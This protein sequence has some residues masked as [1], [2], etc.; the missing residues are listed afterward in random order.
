[1]LPKKNSDGTY[2][3]NTLKKV[4]DP[5]KGN[6]S[7]LKGKKAESKLSDAEEYKGVL[8]KPLVLTNKFNDQIN[9]T[10]TSEEI[11][12]IVGDVGSEINEDL[13][14]W[15]LFGNANQG[16]N[17][18]NLNEQAET[19]VLKT[20][21][22]IVDFI[23]HDLTGLHEMG[24]S[25]ELILKAYDVSGKEL[26]VNEARAGNLPVKKLEVSLM[27]E[28]EEKK[29]SDG[30]ELGVLKPLQT[31]TLIIDENGISEQNLYSFLDK[32]GN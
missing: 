1:M 14:D 28:V 19:R 29:D 30:Y 22:S 15:G 32:F 4:K 7:L 3:A 12:N 26:N 31:E 16:N 23:I 17:S 13:E 27:K 18:E 9:R 20:F 2:P 21:D 8:K 10:L 6:L 25:D 5:L 11:K 24:Y